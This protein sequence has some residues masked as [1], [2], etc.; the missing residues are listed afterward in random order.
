ML[1]EGSSKPLQ[2]ARSQCTWSG[3]RRAQAYGAW[4][5]VRAW[6]DVRHA[7]AARTAPHNTWAPSPAWVHLAALDAGQAGGTHTRGR[8][9]HLRCHC[10]N[11][12]PWLGEARRSWRSAPVTTRDNMEALSTQHSRRCGDSG[13]CQGET[14][15]IISN[16]GGPAPSH[17]CDYKWPCVHLAAA[18]LRC[19]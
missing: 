10:R 13:Q 6:L 19:V 4:V 1:T 8:E 14:L 16:G 9:K 17:R 5:T 7:S 2:A 3:G 11:P 15:G 18:P 12:S